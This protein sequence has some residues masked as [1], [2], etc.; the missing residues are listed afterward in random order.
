MWEVREEGR[1]PAMPCDGDH[2]D[3]DGDKRLVAA[4]H[5]GSDKVPGKLPL[6][7]PAVSVVFSHAVLHLP[8]SNR[9]TEY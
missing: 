7:L 8:A 2:G 6:Q 3:G 1:W 5:V 9:Q 4:T